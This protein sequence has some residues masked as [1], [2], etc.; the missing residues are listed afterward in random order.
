MPQKKSF[1]FMRFFRYIDFP[2]NFIIY[3]Q[4]FE[5]T[6]IQKNNILLQKTKKITTTPAMCHMIIIKKDV[7]ETFKHI[8]N[9]LN[10]QLLAPK[11][12]ISIDEIFQI[13]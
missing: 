11:I 6:T 12:N 7:F 10:C 1:P 4:I 2:Q 8:E 9:I 5:N 3:Q 13:Y